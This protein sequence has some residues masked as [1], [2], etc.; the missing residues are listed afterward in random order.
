MVQNADDAG[1]TEVNFCLD[2][3]QHGIEK[4]AYRKM[5]VFQGNNKLCERKLQR[6]RFCI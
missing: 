6:S 4:L 2:R 3:R 1:A 5:E